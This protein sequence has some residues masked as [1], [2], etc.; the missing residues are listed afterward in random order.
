MLNRLGLLVLI[1]V[2]FLACEQ[3]KPAVTPPTSAVSVSPTSILQQKPAP[4]PTAKL[5][6]L[7]VGTPAPHVTAVTPPPLPTATHTPVPTSTATPRPTSTPPPLPTATHTP[8]P[9]STATP[10]P[11]STPIPEPTATA[12]P[13]PTS[14]PIPEPTATNTP[15]PTATPIPIVL[16]ALEVESSVAGYWSNSSADVTLDFTLVNRGDL[17][18]ETVQNVR[19]TCGQDSEV[20]QGCN[21]KAA[22]NLT[23]GYG[24]GSG[25]FDLRLPMGTMETVSLDYGG[26]EPFVVDVE[27]PARI[28]DLE[29][30]LV[31]CYVDREP[32]PDQSD[33][34]LRGCG[35]WATKTV[36]KWLNDVPVKVWATGEPAYIEDFHEVLT[37]LSPVL[38]LDFVTVDSEH[39]AD[40]R[41]YIGVRREDINHLGFQPYL[42]D[43]GGFGDASKVAGEATSGFVVVWYID[44]TP[45][46]SITLHEALHALVPIYH[47]A[48]PLSAVGGSG[49]ALLS[50]RDEALFRLNAHPLVRP[51]MTMQE[52][53]QLI[54]FR[55]E[56]LDRPEPEPVTDPIQILWRALE[57][58]DEAGTAGYKLSGGYTGRQ[59]G[60]TFGVRRGP[61]PFKIGRFRFW[62]DDPALL[63]F[64]DHRNE[65]YIH[66]SEPSNEWQ[67]HTRPLTGGEWKS[68]SH[69][70]LD[71]LTHW[72][73]WNG[74]LHRSLRSILQDGSDEDITV[75]TTDDGNISLHVTMDDSFVHLLLW[76]EG[77]RVKTVDFTLTLDPDTFA[78]KGYK[79]VLRYEPPADYPDYPCLTYEEL[80]TDFELGVE[81][82]LPDDI[83]E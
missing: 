36:D 37:G 57:S 10:R 26:H 18:S 33:Q 63:Y 44:D 80:A 30:D 67:R 45:P 5:A 41:G 22:L 14:T 69:S 24:P 39:E 19:L 83:P 1:A 6:L 3:P 27:A 53:R 54:V 7:P 34:F 35:G 82:E 59:C 55:D 60:Q 32:V 66:Y 42:V 8:V 15:L 71:G 73:L 38:N 21:Q 81:I 79:W 40:L 25:S 51:G 43:Y 72:W 62:A 13:R 46:T 16:L 61:L 77:W 4:S 76:G 74:K 70:E 50:P 68:L 78:I 29:R 75:D 47:T 48:R 64:H 65:F 56:L 12:T 52:V 17:P 2:I 58:L 20:L 11:T 23:D 49:M 28:L 9:T 31:A